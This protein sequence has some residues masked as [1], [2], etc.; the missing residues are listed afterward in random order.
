MNHSKTSVAAFGC[1]IVISLRELI[2]IYIRS[3]F[4]GDY[5]GHFVKSKRYK[6]WLG[7]MNG[8]NLEENGE[9]IKVLRNRGQ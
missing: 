8:A 3:P 7:A 5:R 4:H 1:A 2:C 6:K 9:Q